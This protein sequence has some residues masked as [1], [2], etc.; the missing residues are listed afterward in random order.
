[1]HADDVNNAAAA[2]DIV[3]AA[4]AADAAQDS[5]GTRYDSW[6]FAVAESAIEVENASRFD[7]E[8]AKVAKFHVYN[9]DCLLAHEL[10]PMVFA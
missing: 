3:V 8:C 10:K 4:A 1:M 5:D 9:D 7:D 2:D 6:N